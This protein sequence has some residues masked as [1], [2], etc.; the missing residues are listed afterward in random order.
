MKT[1]IKSTVL[2]LSMM[3]SIAMAT[4]RIDNIPHPVPDID[5]EFIMAHVNFTGFAKSKLTVKGC[6]SPRQINGGI[7]FFSNSDNTYTINSSVF[8]T[9]IGDRG[10][11]D[12]A[13]FMKLNQTSYDAVVSNIQTAITESCVSSNAINHAIIA[14]SVVVE[15]HSLKRIGRVAFGEII[16]TG[17]VASVNKFNDKKQYT[18]FKYV[19][20]Y[21]GGIKAVLIR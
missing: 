9:M 3:S 8:G 2:I 17:R 13:V 15:K 11:D 16:I 21:K 7:E 6:V 18:D 1:L 12:K 10:N 19:G 14:S 20:K 5:D 4:V